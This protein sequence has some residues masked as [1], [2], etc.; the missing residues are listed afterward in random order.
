M[1]SEENYISQ[2][3]FELNSFTSYSGI[4]QNFTKSWKNVYS[5]LLHDER[6][7]DQIEKKI[8]KDEL[9]ILKKKDKNLDNA[10]EIFEFI[11]P[12]GVD[13]FGG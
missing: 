10:K 9:K 11:P 13:V 4:K 3:K 12:E 5:E 6:F 1:S 2:V 8:F 7:G